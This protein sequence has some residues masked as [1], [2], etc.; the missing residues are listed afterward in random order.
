MGRGNIGD[1]EAAGRWCILRT[2]GG[3]TLPLAKSLTDVGMEAFTPTETRRHKLRAGK[4]GMVEKAMPMLPTFVFVREHH[5]A[6][7]FEILMMPISPHPAFSF[8]R[9][10]GVVK[11]IPD[12]EVERLRD[13][14]QRSKPR[15]ARP[16]L[17]VGTTVKPKEGPYAGLSGVVEASKN[18]DCLVFFGGWMKVEIET[19][20]LQPF[21]V[22]DDQPPIGKAAP[23]HRRARAVA[24][25][26]AWRSEASAR[27]PAV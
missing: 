16:T 21:D 23:Q 19:L 14:E 27:C 13:A 8:F 18:G 2:S 17:P 6:A 15:A 4:K 26:E 24:G 20:N 9:H 5:Q 11:G 7:L 25:A 3:K 1:G 22:K 10:L 12:R